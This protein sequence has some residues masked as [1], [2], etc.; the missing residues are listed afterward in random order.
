VEDATVTQTAK[1]HT[2]PDG[3][4]TLEH[5]TRGAC[6][7]AKHPQPTAASTRQ[8]AQTRPRRSSPKNGNR[9]QQLLPRKNTIFAQ[10]SD[11]QRTRNQPAFR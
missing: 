9:Q 7:Q 8:L 4:F 5:L 10:S 3:T 6:L 1:H 2:E 11:P